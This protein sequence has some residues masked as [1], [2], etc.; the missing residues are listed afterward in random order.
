M[1]VPYISATR[2]KMA[3]DCT[4]AYEFQY[5]PSGE[6]ERIL[7]KKSNHPEN[8]QAARLGNIVHGALEDWRLPDAKTGKPTKPKFG[9]LMRHYELWAAKPEFAVDF[10][11]YQDGKQML[12]R[13]FDRR[14][15]SPV[16]VYATEQPMGQHNAPFILDN[17]VPIYGFIDL[18]LEHKDG[19]IELVD[20]KT[21]RLHKTQNEADTD[22]QAGIYLS[23]ARQ[24]FPDRPL[25]FTFDMIRWSP[26]STVW[27]DE[28]ID[29]FGGW[30]KAQYESIKVLDK[31]KATLGDSCK[32]CAYQSICPEVQT[33]IF[34]GAFDLVAS[35]FDND[36]EQL[37]ALATIKAAQGILNKRR[38]VIEKELKGRLNPL[39]H[40]ETIETDT[41][42]VEYIK[43]ERSEFIPSEVQRIVPPAV[44]GQITSLSKAAVERV[45]PILPEEMAKRVM[46]TQI[47]KP[48]NAMTIKRKKQD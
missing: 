31:G 8:T 40:T 45:L 19:T 10:E 33:L 28:Q 42:S 14:G 25:R 34:K 29:S 7:K 6:S 48:Y 43:K 41:W 46:D 44:F 39:D 15:K 16:R 47:K 23:W 5:D 27:T 37:D 3:K 36:D 20:Y 4:L 32:W 38:S 30:L 21:N 12:K 9:A 24:M 2:L 11:F 22:V 17:G 26:V 1:K 13:W 18:I 35:D